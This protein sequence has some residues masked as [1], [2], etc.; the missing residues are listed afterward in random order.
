MSPNEKTKS[1][2]IKPKESVPQSAFLGLFSALCS[3]RTPL[4]GIS[5]Q[6]LSSSS[7]NY[8]PLPD[9]IRNYSLHFVLTGEKGEEE[10]EFYPVSKIKCFFSLFPFIS[11]KVN[12][13][14]FSSHEQWLKTGL[15]TPNKH[16]N[17]LTQNF[18]V[19]SFL[20]LLFL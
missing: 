5:S 3:N 8:Y 2:H 19:C 18:R 15:G 6:S 20:L 14:R 4:A 16:R 7:R 12:P 11:I 10:E 13:L 17:S 1:N 9:F